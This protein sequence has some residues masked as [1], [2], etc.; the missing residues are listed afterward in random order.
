MRTTLTYLIDTVNTLRLIFFRWSKNILY[1]DLVIE[2][3]GSRR[4]GRQTPI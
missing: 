4:S 3:E 2:Q 1:G